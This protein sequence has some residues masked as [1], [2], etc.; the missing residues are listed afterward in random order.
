MGQEKQHHNVCHVSTATTESS[1][2]PNSIDHGAE[3]NGVGH[4]NDGL[5]GP[6]LRRD[7]LFHH[8]PALLE[9]CL[10]RR[11]QPGNILILRHWNEWRMVGPAV[12]FVR[13]QGV[14]EISWACHSPTTAEIPMISPL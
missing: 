5:P 2:R 10:D 11:R 12:L 1:P 7:L 8:S 9:V 4:E 3:T 13:L 6:R 14:G